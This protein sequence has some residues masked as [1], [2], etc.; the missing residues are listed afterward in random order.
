MIKNS[1]IFFEKMAKNGNKFRIPVI[2]TVWHWFKNRSRRGKIII[3][4]ILAAIIYWRYSAAKNGGVEIDVAKVAREKLTENVSA[5]GDVI[6]DN[7]A[8]LV[9]QTAGE[10]TEVNFKEGDTVKKG[11]IIAKLD[12]T[13]LYNNYLIA[14]ANLRAA[15]ATLD[16]VYD[17]LQGHETDESFT[18]IETRTAAETAKDKTYWS[19]ASASKSLEG[20]Y[21][22]APF[23]GV[24]TQVP[25][26]IVK[27]SV[28]SLPSS[29]TFQVVGP[30]TTFFE[31]EVSEVDIIK[32]TSGAKANIDIDA[33]P[34]ETFDGTVSGLGFES[35]TTSTGG[36][37][38]HVR[39]TLPENN[40][41]KFMIGMNGDADI[42]LSEKS[43]V[44]LIPVNS[45]VEED[46]KTYVWVVENSK[47][48]KQEINTG[49]SSINDIEVISG[50]S[51]GQEVIVRP[52]NDI[53]EGTKIKIKESK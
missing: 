9:F 24:V 50:L 20:A 15:E 26:D 7:S 39:I 49:I 44:L 37:A 10:V 51:E 36:T 5:S 43:N 48:K 6:A 13:L 41:T 19:F 29:A 14:Q 52:S 3:I 27:G 38:Y 25:Q 32:I 12:T 1:G 33:Y 31:A 34:D 17:D 35:I 2:T 53:Q 28:I 4:L 18:Q 22:R 47:A 30:E 16:R 42:I 8:N 46:D 45:L 21:I 23:D 11:D 40:D